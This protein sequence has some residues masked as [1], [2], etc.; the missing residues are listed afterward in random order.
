MWEM[1]DWTN[2]A[3]HHEEVVFESDEAMI[4]D[5]SPNAIGEVTANALMDQFVSDEFIT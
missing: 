2:P 4:Y 3:T 1:H 5:F